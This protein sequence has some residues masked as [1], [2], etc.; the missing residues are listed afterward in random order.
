MKKKKKII[1]VKTLDLHGL[2]R[3]DAEFE[4]EEFFN[5]LKE[6]NIKKCKIITGWGKE[7]KPVL[8]TFTKDWLSAKGYEYDYDFGSFL[9][10]LNN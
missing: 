8:F 10:Y 4:L 7:Q 3:F 5:Q 6:K 9:V 2:T 1:N